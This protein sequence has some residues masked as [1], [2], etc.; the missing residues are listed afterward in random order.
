[1]LESLRRCYNNNYCLL[2]T[3]KIVELCT[4]RVENATFE[5]RRI[6][7]AAG[8][9]QTG[10][11]VADNTRTEHKLLPHDRMHAQM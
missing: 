4:N 7:R 6:N 1:M 10:N 2:D 11:I 8:I 9:E 5:A 3:S